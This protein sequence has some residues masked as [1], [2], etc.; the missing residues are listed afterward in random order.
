MQVGHS[1]GECVLEGTINHLYITVIRK[2]KSNNTP[3]S[4]PCQHTC[5]PGT[6][7]TEKPK[8]WVP[9]KQLQSSRNLKSTCTCIY[10]H[11]L[12]GAQRSQCANH[13]AGLGDTPAG[14]QRLAEEGRCLILSVFNN[15]ERTTSNLNIAV[16]PLTKNRISQESLELFR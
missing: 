8:K 5:K 4:E 2:V 1:A 12:D 16:A 14:P 6:S 10:S 11:R 13:S 9:W 15:E 3:S 7:T